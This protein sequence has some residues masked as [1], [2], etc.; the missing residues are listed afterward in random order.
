MEGELVMGCM[1]RAAARVFSW[2]RVFGWARVRVFGQRIWRW[3]ILGW[4]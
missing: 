2:A 1:P 3:F 4:G